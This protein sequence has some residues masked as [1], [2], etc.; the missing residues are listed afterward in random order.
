MHSGKKY[1]N[2]LC[3]RLMDESFKVCD[4]DGMDIYEVGE[5]ILRRGIG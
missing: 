1:S 2:A 3:N 4:K 5:E